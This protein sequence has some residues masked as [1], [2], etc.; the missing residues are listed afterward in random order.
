MLQSQK[1]RGMVWPPGQDTEGPARGAQPGI[2]GDSVGLRPLAFLHCP[3]LTEFSLRVNPGPLQGPGC[4]LS[5]VPIVTVG[6]AG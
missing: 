1:T 6:M 4:A 2:C 5:Q 3:G